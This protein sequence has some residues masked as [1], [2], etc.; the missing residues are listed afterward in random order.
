MSSSGS[1]HRVRQLRRIAIRSVISTQDIVRVCRL[2]V[3]FPEEAAGTFQ[4]MSAEVYVSVTGRRHNVS[5][6][7][8]K[9]PPTGLRSLEGW[10]LPARSLSKVVELP[11]GVQFT[12]IVT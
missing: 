9:P 5:Q 2:S 10:I 12:S 11:S 4:P 8:S 6:E 3:T 7:R 1:G